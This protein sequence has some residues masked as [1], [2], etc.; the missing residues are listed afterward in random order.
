MQ[1]APWSRRVALSLAAPKKGT[2]SECS[3]HPGSRVALEE[4]SVRAL[5]HPDPAYTFRTTNPADQCSWF[6]DYQSLHAELFDHGH[7]NMDHRS[8]AFSACNF[9]SSILLRA[10]AIEYWFVQAPLRKQ[11]SFIV[12]IALAILE[13][14][15]AL[16]VW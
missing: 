12:F 7:K 9:G 3:L 4:R 2:S 1:A 11:F 8:Y 6:S 15:L 16:A 5:A 14:V 10:R 13:E